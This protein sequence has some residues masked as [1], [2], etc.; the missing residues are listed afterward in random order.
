MT[1]EVVKFTDPLHI[2]GMQP[3]WRAKQKKFSLLG[4]EIYYGKKSYCSVL[5]FHGRTRG[6][7]QT[8]DHTQAFQLVSQISIKGSLYLSRLK[9]V[10]LRSF[11]WLSDVPQVLR[12]YIL[13][14]QS[15]YKVI[16]FYCM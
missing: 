4:I 15:R 14:N 12:N 8:S 2:M 3:I 13:R 6:L 7:F 5:H 11:Q 1:L 16:L 10:F 9:L